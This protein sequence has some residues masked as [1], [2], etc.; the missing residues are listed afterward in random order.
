M[1]VAESLVNS[2][3]YSKYREM[4]S[5]LIDE[6]KSTGDNQSEDILHYSKLNEA[7]MNRLD[8]KTVISSEVLQKM[9]GLNKN[10]IW[11]L[12]TEGWC[13][14]AAHIVP[15]IN[16]LASISKSVDLKI[17]LRDEND[18]LMKMF[19]TNGSKSIPILV[20]LDESNLKVLGNWGPRPEGASN[21]IASYKG[22]YGKIDDTAKTEVQLWYNNDKGESIQN[23]IADFMI[24]LDQMIP[25]NH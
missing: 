5:T 24:Q 19:L 2:M 3:S 7:R 21:L 8:K 20:V 18:N 10:Y 22:Q 16:K 14:D 11:L 23:E 9:M 15:V 17:V 13:G 25:Q 4:V 6:R 12:I 1:P